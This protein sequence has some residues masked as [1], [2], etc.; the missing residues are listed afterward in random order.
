VAFALLCSFAV[1]NQSAYSQQK[2][3]QWNQYRGPNGDGTSSAT[4]LPVKW[5]ETENVKWKTPVRGKA[6]SSPVVWN[7]QI[8]VTTALPDGKQLFAICLDRTTGKVVHDVTV[9]E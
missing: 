8:W 4:G 9:F 3:E 7:D 6:W 2:P 5:S 1:F